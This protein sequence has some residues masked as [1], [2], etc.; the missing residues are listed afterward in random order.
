MASTDCCSCR[1]T[2]IQINKKNSGIG[3]RGWLTYDKIQV[4]K[5][6]L[7]DDLTTRVPLL[8]GF[9]WFNKA[10][11]SYPQQW[12]TIKKTHIFK[13]GSIVRKLK[14][15]S[16]LDIAIRDWLLSRCS[17]IL[18]FYFGTKD[19]WD[20]GIDVIRCFAD[21]I[22]LFNCP[23]FATEVMIIV[24]SILR[25]FECI[26]TASMFNSYQCNLW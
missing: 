21:A 2:K 26:Q 10:N 4:S 18:M 25:R 8:G 14:I 23:C 16:F 22:Q 1:V 6:N 3:V 17:E 5:K 11:S 7:V 15:L 19:S 9:H 13:V 20:F 12:P 24:S